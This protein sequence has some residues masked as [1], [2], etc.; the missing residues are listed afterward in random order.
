[1]SE[2]QNKKVHFIL[3]SKGGVGKSL[4][5][6]LLAQYFLYTEDNK[7]EKLLLLDTDPLNKTFSRFNKLNVKE[8]L[9]SES[10]QGEID[11]RY[12]DDIIDDIVTTEAK[13]III[14]TGASCFIPL[15]FY[16]ARNHII[17]FLTNFNIKVALHSIVAGGQ[18]FIDTI[19]GLTTVVRQLKMTTVFTQPEVVLWKNP[20]FGKIEHPNGVILEQ[21][22]QYQELRGLINYEISLPVLDAQTEARDL[23]IMLADGVTFDEIKAH[24]SY[25]L[26]M[27]ARLERIKNE[28]YD[29]IR[30]T[31]LE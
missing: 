8:V 6:T 26:M 17:D 21:Y 15:G 20:F 22:A 3:Q 25:T 16:L 11:K 29:E 24:Q 2:E 7:R 12:F 13:H 28:I 1:M 9:L 14:D 23:S 31:G 4:I 10:G 19:D 30:N 27:K 18:N 5:S